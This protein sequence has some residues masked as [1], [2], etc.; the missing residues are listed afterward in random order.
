MTIFEFYKPLD[1]AFKAQYEI[2]VII[3]EIVLKSFILKKT[4]PKI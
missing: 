2:T 3:D 4:P 1:Y